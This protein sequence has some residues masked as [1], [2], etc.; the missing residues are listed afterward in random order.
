MVFPNSAG[1]ISI[2][3]HGQFL[4]LLLQFLTFVGFRNLHAG[5]HLLENHMLI[6]N[7]MM[8]PDDGLLSHEGLV[9]HDPEMMGAVKECSSRI[10]EIAD[11]TKAP[12]EEK[13]VET[14]MI[15]F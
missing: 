4:Y 8:L 13:A 5:I 1:A 9:G 3:K 14:A 10:Y 15:A 6:L 7:V 2:Q 12:T 11:G